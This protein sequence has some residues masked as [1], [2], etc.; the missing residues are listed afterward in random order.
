[1]RLGNYQ[2]QLQ[3]AMMQ[4]L[5]QSCRKMVGW[6][7][8]LESQKHHKAKKMRLSARLVLKPNKSLFPLMIRSL[9]AQVLSVLGQCPKQDALKQKQPK[10]QLG[11][12]LKARDNNMSHS[13][14]KNMSH[15]SGESLSG[16]QACLDRVKNNSCTICNK[17]CKETQRVR[18]LLVSVTRIIQ[19]RDSIIKLIPHQGSQHMATIQFFLSHLVIS[20][21][22]KTLKKFKRKF[23]KL[24][25]ET[26]TYIRT[27]GIQVKQG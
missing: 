12:S 8:L 25:K 1:M 10:Q 5:H 2:I 7:Q 26:V 18:I 4:I 20:I 22:T 6:S 11:R 27:G 9:I 21:L 14:Q 13:S 17:N 24:L 23:M 3:M 16:A 19:G 15:Q